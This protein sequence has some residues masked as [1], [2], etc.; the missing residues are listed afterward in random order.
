MQTIRSK[1]EHTCVVCGD[2]I[3]VGDRVAIRRGQR[4]CEECATAEEWIAHTL[5]RGKTPADACPHCWQIPSSSGHC[6]CA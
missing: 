1:I 3:S 2:Q 4:I 6:E 5:P